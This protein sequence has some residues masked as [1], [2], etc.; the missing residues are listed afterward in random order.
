MWKDVM[1]AV[2]SLAK[3]RTFTIVSILT[4][5]LGIGATTAIFSVI[6]AVLLHP[7]PYPDSEKIVQ[8]ERVFPGGLAGTSTS[9][10]KFVV[11]REQVQAFQDVAAYDFGGPGV[12]LTLGDHP[13]QLRPSTFQK[14][15]LEF[16]A[17]RWLSGEP[18][19]QKKTSLRGRT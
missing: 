15:T 11:W 13:E 6:D 7:L 14:D 9:I 19:V 8:L 5:A 4:L 1:Y 2:R 18:L 10:P 12:N 17:H 3:S 16:L